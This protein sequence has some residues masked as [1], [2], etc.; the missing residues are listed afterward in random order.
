MVL[1]SVDWGEPVLSLLSRFEGVDRGRPAVLIVRHSEVNYRTVDDLI[2][3]EL[4]ERGE[5]AAREFGSRLPADFDYRL[6]HTSFTRTRQTAEGMAGGLESNGARVSLGGE[7]PSMNIPQDQELV[8]AIWNH[9][10]GSW[11][12]SDWLSHRLPGTLFPDPLDLAKRAAGEVMEQLRDAR[13]GSVDVYA[14][15]GEMVALYKFYWLGIP[16]MRGKYGYLNGFILQLDDDTF[17]AHT[18]EGTSR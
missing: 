6:F 16:P 3:A 10:E 5:E 4:T 15:H 18:Q 13:P 11:F 9:P 8:E 7:L 12:I 1:D 2:P 17:T 14:S